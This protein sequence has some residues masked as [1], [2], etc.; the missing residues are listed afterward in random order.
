MIIGICGNLGQ[1]KTCT[2]TFL[3]H[4]FWRSGV[5]IYGNYVLKFPFT[6]VDSFDTIGEIRNG[7][8]LGDELWAWADSRGFGLRQ[9]RAIAA[10]LLKSRKHGLDIFFTAQHFKQID[11]RIRRMTDMFILPDLDKRS[12]ICKV[13]FYNYFYD[14]V[15]KPIQYDATKIFGLY[16]TTEEVEDIKGFEAE[17]AIQK[18]KEFEALA[19]A[20]AL[21]IQL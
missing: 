7:I 18:I 9:N 15:R 8:F 10:I 3:G 12:M 17:K 6:P 20:K 11:I 21:G 4:L 19:K 16:D 13:H 1:G 14:R 2:L 5:T